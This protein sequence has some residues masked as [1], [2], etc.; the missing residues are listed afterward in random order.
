MSKFKSRKVGHF[1]LMEIVGYQGTQPI[2]KI[3]CDCGKISIRKGSHVYQQRGCGSEC[4]VS[5]KSSKLAIEKRKAS[6]PKFN[7]QGKM[8]T[9]LQISKATGL[10]KK[11]ISD[12]IKNNIP[13]DAQKYHHRLYRGQLLSYWVEHLK[14]TK[15][16]FTWRVRTYGIDD[17]RTYMKKS[18]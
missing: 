4:P 18:G 16:A 7:F 1:L 6:A 14:I 5:Q 17:D 15:S 3:K 9:I 11:C 8:L 12:R 10:T 13:L 2:Y